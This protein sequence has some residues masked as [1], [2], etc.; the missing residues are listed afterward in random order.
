ME[1]IGRLYLSG[2]I[3]ER[4]GDFRYQNLLDSE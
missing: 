1:K 2:V 4:A 3:I